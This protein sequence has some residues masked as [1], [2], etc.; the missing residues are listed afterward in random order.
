MGDASQ[1]A[2]H[3]PE[4]VVERHRDTQSVVFGQLHAIADQFAVVEDIGVGECGA[5]GVARGATGELDIDGTVGIEA[6][7]QLGQPVV[8]SLFAEPAYLAEI[9]HAR[10]VF[11]AHAY[12]DLQVW[13]LVRAQFPG[14]AVCNLRGQFP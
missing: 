12:D 2:H 5:L 6:L 10:R 7:A 13:Q 11:L 4:A 3:H 1:I 8:L 14:R 9:V